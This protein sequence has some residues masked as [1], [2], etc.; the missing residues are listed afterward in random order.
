[1]IETMF[2]LLMGAFMLWW[3]WLIIVIVYMDE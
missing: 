2:N 3:A 1:M